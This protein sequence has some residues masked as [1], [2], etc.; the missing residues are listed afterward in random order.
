ME[1]VGGIIVCLHVCVCVCSGRDKTLVF[2]SGDERFGCARSTTTMI[3][4]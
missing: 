3:S 1:I 4:C 2:G